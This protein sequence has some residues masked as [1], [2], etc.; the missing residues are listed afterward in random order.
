MSGLTA[1]KA[2]VSL[3][4]VNDPTSVESLL[5][6]SNQTTLPFRVFAKNALPKPNINL[7]PVPK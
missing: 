5:K 1:R 3:T 7:T 6:S 2:E 4:T